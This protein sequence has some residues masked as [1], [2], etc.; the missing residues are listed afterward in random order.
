MPASDFWI[1]AVSAQADF[2]GFEVERNH[3]FCISK[4]MLLVN[5]I[6]ASMADLEK[7]RRIAQLLN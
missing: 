5:F 1:L 4:K 6:V 3:T 7:N 2:S